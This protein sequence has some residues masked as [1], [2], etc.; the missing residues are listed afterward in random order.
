M[1]RWVLV[2]LGLLATGWAVETWEVVRVGRVDYVSLDSFAKFYGF[3]V[4]HEI[5]NN[6]PFELISSAGSLQ[7]TLD[8]REMRWK[9]ARY[10]LSHSVR[11]ESEVVLI[12][13]VDLVKTFD[14]LL[15]PNG[16][17]PRRP[18]QG[19]VIPSLP[20]KWQGLQTAS[21]TFQQQAGLS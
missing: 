11:K 1:I 21:V 13:R 14:P 6:R 9:G 12:P 17:I 18:L 16:E 20:L 5:E 10:W 4:P 3:K 15:R 7:L 2:V 8:S 19:V